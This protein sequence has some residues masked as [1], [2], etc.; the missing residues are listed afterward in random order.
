MDVYY[1]QITNT[2]ISRIINVNVIQKDYLYRIQKVNIG[3]A[4]INEMNSKE[5]IGIN[6]NLSRLS[7]LYTNSYVISVQYIG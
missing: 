1:L 3:N 6:C 4:S 7:L 2:V 5:T